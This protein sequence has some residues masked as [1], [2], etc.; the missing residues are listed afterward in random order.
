MKY[1]LSTAISLLMTSTPALADS[2]RLNASWYGPGFHG[3]AT[4]NGEVFDMH[5][6]SAAHKSLPFGTRLL[7]CNQASNQST[8]CVEVVINDRGPFIA[9]RDIDLSFGAAQA[10]DLVEAGVA[11]VQVFSL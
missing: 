3:R 9:G 2:T 11:N 4:A 1:L 8:K 6:Y 10:I 7:V 5:G